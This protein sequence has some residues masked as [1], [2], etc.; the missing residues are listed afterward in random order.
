MEE[1]QYIGETLWIH[2][3]GQFLTVLAFIAAAFS[4]YAYYKDASFI[5]KHGEI[6]SWKNLGRIGYIT[7]GFSI[8]SIIAMLFYAMGSQMYEYAYVYQHVNDALPKQYILSAFWEGQEGSF[9]LW[10]FWHIILGFILILRGGKWESS[11][12]MIVAL[13]EVFISSMI[14]GL[15]IEIGDISEKIGVNPVTLLREMQEAPIF[16]NA[17][18][19]SLI[20][21]RGLN[22]LL[23]NYWM[24]I[25]PP[26]VFLGFAS[27][28]IPFAW[29]MAAIY[30]KGDN[31]W[32]KPAL[33]WALF[34][35][36]ILG[37]GILMGGA[38][39][40]EALTFGGYWAWD[41]VENSS[42]VPW[43]SLVAGVH[44]HLIAKHTGYSIRS[45]YFLYI[46]AFILI[47]YS[48]F[49]TRS[50]ILGDTS[51]HAFTDLGLESQLLIFVGFFIL[52]GFGYFFYNYKKIPEPKREES[53]YS[54]EFWM[55]IGSLVLLFSVVLIIGATSLPV[56]NKVVQIFDPEFKGMVIKDP[57]SHYNKYQLWIAV[58]ISLLSGSII[59]F[60]YRMKALKGTRARKLMTSIGISLALAIVSSYL[61]SMWIDYKSW[62]YALLS[63]C[64]FFGLFSNLYYLVTSL[65]ANVRMAAAAISH[66]G[67]ALMII[68]VLT[69]GLNEYHISN[70]PFGQ[71][72]IVQ[73]EDLQDK[74][75]LYKNKPLPLKDGYWVN[76]R[77]NSLEG[78]TRSFELDFW[79]QDETGARVDEF[80]LIPSGLMTLDMT[81]MVARVPDTRHYLNRDIFVSVEGAPPSLRDAALAKEIEDST[82][83]KQ[84]PVAVGD[85]FH[86][87][88]Y[89]GKLESV[90]FSPQN[91]K[92][93]KEN[94]DFAIEAELSFYDEKFDTSF[95]AYP[96]LTLD[97][98]LI[99]TIP[100]LINPFNI[101]VKL[102]DSLMN[103][104]L[105]RQIDLDYKTY[106]L[107]TGETIE[108]DGHSVTLTG[109]NKNPTQRNYEPQ[110]GDI[111][112][113]AVLSIDQQHTVEPI[114]LIREDKPMHFNEYVPQSGIHVRFVQINPA[115]ESFTFMLASEGDTDNV[116]YPI[117]LT[118][119]AIRDDWIYME[120]R[121]FPGINLFW[122]GSVLMMAGFFWSMIARMG[123]RKSTIDG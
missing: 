112:V 61:L 100:D 58:F 3:I 106:V 78:N 63:V 75:L 121:V 22:A 43:I 119:E 116:L 83:Y 101:K 48:T 47:I 4:A 21:G 38:W 93:K 27:L 41:P 26:V 90:N 110:E 28:T 105:E 18:Y 1:I 9:M 12:L 50:G 111:A 40:Y 84:Y 85:T 72:G 73:D 30:N 52:L 14:L 104:W 34:S 76:Y 11:V 86:T 5:K 89:I 117:E 59:F 49:L 92:F 107:K 98:S 57:I 19:L 20:E 97:K 10:M 99:I 69:S 62:Q 29:S 36:G 24:T 35:G 64:L 79:K 74:V 96:V 109:F 46:L 55:Y 23:Q 15:H 16:A 123:S 33:N 108:I 37:I 120:A 53:I 6:S 87:E 8:I 115:E 44:T 77:S 2:H 118:E 17:D 31:T 13:V 82:I 66:G 7:H 113:S 67:F 42:L 122:I 65:K 45:T 51:V 25:H 88:R 81:E 56:Y 71:K 54:R 70:D 68:G 60:Q 39:A 114:F 102:N 94:S 32:M 95:Y 103:T 80:S 91:P